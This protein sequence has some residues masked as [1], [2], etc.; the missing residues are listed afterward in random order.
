M[1]QVFK[2]PHVLKSI[3]HG[4]S[5]YEVGG[6]DMQETEDEDILGHMAIRYPVMLGVLEG[7]TCYCVVFVP[8]EKMFTNVVK[9]EDFGS[10]GEMIDS[11]VGDK[12][13][14]VTFIEKQVIRDEL[15]QRLLELQEEQNHLLSLISRM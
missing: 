13:F 3:V 5:E 9:V 4:F 15:V 7:K 1:N 14:H 12:D 2:I 10:D 8:E 11:V 6:L